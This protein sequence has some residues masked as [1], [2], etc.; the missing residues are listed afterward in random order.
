[1][2]KATIELQ[3]NWI[4]VLFAGALILGFFILLST[5]IQKGSKENLNYELLG[6]MDEI[7]TGMEATDESEHLLTLPAD[8]EMDCNFFSIKGSSYEG[9][10]LQ[11]RIVFGPGLI[12][13]QLVSYS[14]YW[15]IPFKTNVFVLFTSPQIQ[16]VIVGSDAPAKKLYQELPENLN[17]VIVDDLSDF[18]NK[19]YYKL[20]FI[21]F[22]DPE[23][24][25]NV[26]IPDKDVSAV[27]ITSHG[28]SYEFPQG[29]GGV[30]FYHKIGNTFVSDGSS[31]YINKAALF[32]AIYS[33]TKET[34]ECNM[35]KALAR[36][37]IIV[38]MLDKRLDGIQGVK[39]TCSYSDAK[40]K[41]QEIKE[42]LQISNFAVLYDS[43]KELNNI[44]MQLQYQSCPLVY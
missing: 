13:K 15:Q 38:D 42:N 33:E 36:S 23:N 12:K 35:N 2:K 24:I 32:G 40:T 39:S 28:L 34:Y 26:K 10:S 1:M 27:K 17:K 14:T 5:K 6:Y 37:G 4:F 41:L 30:E 25:G 7:F 8:L 19:N 29:Y 22:N 31:S 16:Y 43:Q 21:F 20:R 11:S 18:E 3:F 9:I 44:N